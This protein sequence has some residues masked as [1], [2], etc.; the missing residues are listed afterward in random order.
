MV[1]AGHEVV[2]VE[3]RDRVGGRLWTRREGLLHG[4]FAEL[5]AETLYAGQHNVLSLATRLGLELV[6]CGYFDPE[7][8]GLLLGGRVLPQAERV[9]VTDWLRE[10][11]AASPPA[12][13][14]NLQAWSS[15]LLAPP[16][17]VA[18]LSAFAQYTPVTALRHADAAE[19]ERQ[20][21]HAKEAYRVRGGNDLLASGLANGL[22]VRLR[23]RVRVVRWRDTGA[24]AVTDTGTVRADRIVVTV[25]GPLTVGL[26]FSPSLPPEKVRA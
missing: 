15:R 4:Q 24:E 14:E 7:A 17:V 10:R 11:Y 1:R 20:L 2:L 23:E 12:P 16:Q 6:P 18:F 3:A 25:P 9:A 19:F 21:T 13:F 5:G 26:G 22:D 8:P